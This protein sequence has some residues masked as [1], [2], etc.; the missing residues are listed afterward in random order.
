[1]VNN[2]SLADRAFAAVE[3]W[4]LIWAA[5]AAN[6][7]HDPAAVLELYREHVAEQYPGLLALA[8]EAAD[9]PR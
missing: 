1:M 3:T 4:A 7:G 2:L 9:D 6:S 8:K 5:Y